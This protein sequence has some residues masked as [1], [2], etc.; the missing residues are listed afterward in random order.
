MEQEEDGAHIPEDATG[1]DIHFCRI[2]GTLQSIGLPTINSRTTR[3]DAK[4]TNAVSCTSPRMAVS[5]SHGPAQYHI[6]FRDRK[7]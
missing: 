5:D 3:T 4:T 6:A 7:R 1:G 2:G